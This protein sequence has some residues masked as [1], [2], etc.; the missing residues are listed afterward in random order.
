M[1]IEL[2][3]FQ[4][5]QRDVEL[6]VEQTVRAGVPLPVGALSETAQVT[7]VAPLITTENA[8]VG[9]VIENRRIV[10]LPLNGRNFLS[11]VAL[12]RTSAPNSRRQA[13]RRSPG[14]IARQPAALD[15]GQRHDHDYY[16]LDGTDNTDVN[17]NTYVVPSVDALEEFKV[18]MASTAE[19]GPRSQP[20]E[21]RHQSRARI[22][23]TARCSNS[24]ATTSSTRGRSRSRPPG[25]LL[26]KPSF[27]WNQCGYTLGGPI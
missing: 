13:G 6:H 11:L 19:F 22:S 26:P 7:G 4:T 27:K 5:V 3:G 21:R 20:G 16:T 14:R 24:T 18:P 15:S 10:E 23:S 2:Q 8:T 9:T 12:S 25:R 17:F 1:K